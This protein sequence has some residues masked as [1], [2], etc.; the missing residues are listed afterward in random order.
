MLGP[1]SVGEGAWAIGVSGG[2]EFHQPRTMASILGAL[3]LAGATIGGL[4]LLLPHPSFYDSS[5]LWSNVVFA[6]VAGFALLLLRNRVPSWSLPL[7]VLAGTAVVTRA[8]Y[9]GHDPSGY[10]TIWYLWI[11][12]YAFFFFG[13]R[14]GALQMAFVGLAYGWVLTQLSGPTPV[15]RWVVTVGSILVAGLLVDALAGRLRSE[16]DASA[17][18]AANL[19]AVGEV[20]R[21]LAVQS[22]PRA[23][24]WAICSAA[25]RTAHASVAVLWRPNHSGDALQATAVAG[26]DA[27]GIMLPFVTPS[28]GAIQVFTSATDRFASMRGAKPAQELSPGFEAGAALWEPIL[29]GKSTAVGVLAVYWREH[30]EQLGGETRRA[31]RL[32]AL[33]AAIAIERGELLGRLEVAART[34]DLTGL[35]N[36]R[37]WNEELSRQLSRADRDGGALCVAI[38]DL[39]NFKQ[40]NDSHGHQAGDR[41]LKQMAGAWSQTLRAGDIL[42]RYGGEEF[43]LALPG[44]NLDHARQ[45]LERLCESLPE[46]QTC[47]AGV[48]RWDGA[49]SA[50][51]LTARA[52]TALYAAK[53]AGRDRVV[54]LGS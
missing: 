42:A 29:R 48:C 32:L 50:E 17:R 41:F 34:D 43:A 22:D 7:I 10:Y 28:S 33:E 9:Y 44:T 27:E 37:A 49:Q 52:D 14:W 11:G 24:G 12:V 13:S 31:V 3:F 47:S 2:R 18:R 8:V 36:R 54:G 45:M 6:Y 30:L 5:A 39:D 35:L 46:G 21:Q 38:L 20:A 15:A 19:E 23:V 40:Y 4:S 1:V 25:V 53:D 26:A 51:S 16:T